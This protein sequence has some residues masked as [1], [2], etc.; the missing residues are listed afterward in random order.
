MFKFN[1]ALDDED[2]ILNSTFEG[3]P[4]SQQEN[5]SNR[6]QNFPEDDVLAE[7]SLQDLHSCS[8]S[9]FLHLSHIPRSSYP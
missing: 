5:N 9:L 3:H 1:F 4:P 6:T 2:E 7:H 8:F